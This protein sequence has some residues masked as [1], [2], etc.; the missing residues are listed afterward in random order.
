MKRADKRRPRESIIFRVDKF[1]FKRFSVALRSG[2]TSSP[3]PKE[4]GAMRVER[5]TFTFILWGIG[6][7]GFFMHTEPLI[8]CIIG[9]I[10][11]ST[12][13]LTRPPPLQE[14]LPDKSA[15][16]YESPLIRQTGYQCRSR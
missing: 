13:C 12:H 14:A 8:E 3:P 4:E 15:Q 10:A 16:V 9:S 5:D 6:D 1:F 7:K 11:C 2:Q